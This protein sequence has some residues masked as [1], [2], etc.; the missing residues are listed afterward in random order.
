MQKTLIIIPSRLAATRL[1]GKPLLKINGISII[2][3]VYKKALECNLGEVFVA[4]EDQEILDDIKLNGGEG[5]LTKKAKTG[6]DRVLEAFKKLNRSDVDYI[7]NIQGDEPM[8][9]T[10]DIIN[11]NINT[12]KNNSEM[13]SLGCKLKNNQQLNNESI[14]K[15][16]TLKKIEDNNVSE[17][18]G[19]L[20]K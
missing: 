4:T 9:S 6:T 14:V 16:K 13:G 19:F 5:L 12:L 2:A 11:L 8:I 1:P 20:E 17:A 18:L 3:H 7:L 10:N 15:V